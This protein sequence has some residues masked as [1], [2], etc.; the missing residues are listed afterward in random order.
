MNSKKIHRK[1][2][3]MKIKEITS[4]KFAMEKEK[5]E[6]AAAPK[7][8][9]MTKACLVI[10]CSVIVFFLMSYGPAWT[11]ENKRIPIRETNKTISKLQTDNGQAVWFETD[12]RTDISTLY[13]YNGKETITLQENFSSVPYCLEESTYGKF[14]VPQLDKGQVGREIMN[15]ELRIRN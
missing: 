6:I 12:G 1:E 11:A 2:R 8:L 14:L 3:G 13:F 9:V 15:F 7:C 5:N 10:W 4:P